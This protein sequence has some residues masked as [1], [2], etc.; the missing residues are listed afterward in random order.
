MNQAGEPSAVPSRAD[1][2]PVVLWLRLVRVPNLFTVPGDPLAGLVLATHPDT[3][4]WLP[5]L[6]VVCSALFLYAG[7]MLLNDLMDVDRD[8]AATPWRPLAHGLVGRTQVQVAILVCVVV[9]LAC[10]GIVGKHCLFVAIGL[11]IA[12][13]AY[14]VGLKSVP[15][16]GP[17]VMGSCRGLSV[18]LGAATPTAAGHLSPAGLCAAVAVTLYVLGITWFARYERG[19]VQPR[20][21]AYLPVTGMVAVFLVLTETAMSTSAAARSGFVVL[22]CIAAAA[23]LFAAWNKRI[24]PVTVGALVRALIP[25]QAALIWLGS[26]AWEGRMIACVVAAAWWPSVMLSRRFYA[27]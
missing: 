15:V 24:R 18:L 21:V 11:T 6:A 23:P 1:L 25:L 4:H 20:W 26:D 8:L 9:G 10:A 7:G 16:V 27:S 19:D 13:V 17:L 2:H 12:V 14:N 3:F 22:F 5:I